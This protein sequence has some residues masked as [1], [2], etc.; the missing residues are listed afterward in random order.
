MKQFRNIFL[1]MISLFFVNNGIGK[2]VSDV[3]LHKYTV[4]STVS[5]QSNYAFGTL[6]EGDDFNESFDVEEDSDDTDD[7]FLESRNGKS[8]NTTFAKN[9]NT[10]I[11]YYHPSFQSVKR[12]ILFCSLKLHC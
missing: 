2:S 5:H 6:A 9:T 4:A 7:D 8:L 10:S 3:S 11:F 12:F 1:L